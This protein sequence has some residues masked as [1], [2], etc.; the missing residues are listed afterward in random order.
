LSASKNRHA[1]RDRTGDPW[2]GRTLEWSVSSPAPLYNFAELPTVSTRD[3]FWA[4]KEAHL[5]EGHVHPKEL[6]YQPIHMPKNTPAGFIIAM[7]A[8][9]FGFAIV[10]HMWIPGV[11]GFI[12]MVATMIARTFSTDT[13]YYVSEETVRKT[14]LAHIKEM[15]SNA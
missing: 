5:A 3:Q 2:N 1:L 10:W 8:G 7:F 9:I 14:E 6:H 13:D 4:Y 11:V 15:I 12:G